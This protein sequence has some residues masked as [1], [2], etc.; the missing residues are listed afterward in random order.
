VVFVRLNAAYMYPMMGCSRRALCVRAK[1]KPPGDIRFALY[2]GCV[3]TSVSE[4]CRCRRRSL[5]DIF[6]RGNAFRSLQHIALSIRVLRPRW[7]SCFVLWVPSRLYPGNTFSALGI[8]VVRDVLLY[9]RYNPTPVHLRAFTCRLPFW[10]SPSFVTVPTRRVTEFACALRNYLAQSY[11]CYYV[12][13][14]TPLSIG[15]VIVLVC[16]WRKPRRYNS[17]VSSRY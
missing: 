2:R 5:Y 11:V 8:F 6:G 1:T 15:L 13:L 12:S 10:F 9:R 17:W 16:E 3:A 14:Y 4:L 7:S